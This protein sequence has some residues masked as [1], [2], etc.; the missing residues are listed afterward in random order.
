MRL[1]SG[2]ILPLIIFV[3]IPAAVSILSYQIEQ[4]V[5]YTLGDLGADLVPIDFLYILLFAYALYPIGY[6]SNTYFK[7]RGFQNAIIEYIYVKKILCVI[8]PIFIILGI[9]GR[10]WIELDLYTLGDSFFNTFTLWIIIYTIAINLSYP[11][12]AGIIWI[13][14]R[15]M[16]EDFRFYFAKAC[17]AS[18]SERMEELK[19]ARYLLMGMKSYDKYLQNNLKLHINDIKKVYSKILFDSAIDENEVIKSISAAFDS[20]NRSKLKPAKYL[21]ETLHI[22]EP[23]LFLIDKSLV[24]RVK[25]LAIFFAT[26]IPVVIAII[27]LVFPAQEP[28]PDP[29]LINQTGLADPPPEEQERPA[30]NADSIRQAYAY[31]ITSSINSIGMNLE[32]VESPL[33]VVVNEQGESGELLDIRK[34]DDVFLPSLP[35]SLVLLYLTLIL[36]SL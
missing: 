16:K 21:S 10:Y 1:F 4:P 24:E 34:T 17:F 20:H 25:D 15:S 29:N 6:S 26:V 18:I 28:Q 13:I 23:D 32:T 8:I 30:N 12:I 2:R 33:P 14:I 7:K 11:V 9:M 5:V 27:Q 19:R 35:L 36:P 3:V 31:T 22:Q